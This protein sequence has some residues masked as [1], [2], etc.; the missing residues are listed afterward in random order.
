MLVSSGCLSETQG[1]SSQADGPFA[2]WMCSVLTLVLHQAV[3]HSQ[4]NRCPQ[5]VAVLCLRSSRHSV[6]RD[7][8]PR[9]GSLLVLLINTGTVG[10]IALTLVV[11]NT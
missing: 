7:W 1:I 3:M 2:E 10:L 4:Q 9:A 8:R 6:Q 5:G 11:R